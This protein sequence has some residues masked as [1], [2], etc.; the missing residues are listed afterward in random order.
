MKVLSGRRY[1]VMINGSVKM[2]HINKLK[3]STLNEGI[4][5]SE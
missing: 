2:V 1:L 4:H 3:S 5:Q